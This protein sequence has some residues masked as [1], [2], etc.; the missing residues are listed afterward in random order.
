MREAPKQTS[1][2]LILLAHRE[3]LAHSQPQ[4][5]GRTHRLAKKFQWI[6]NPLP[7]FQISPRRLVS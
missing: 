6:R 2:F 5:F 7:N 1:P 3:R 4:R